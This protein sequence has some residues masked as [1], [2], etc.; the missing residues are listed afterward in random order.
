VLAVMFLAMPGF[1]TWGM[2]TPVLWNTNRAHHEVLLQLPLLPFAAGAFYLVASH[3]VLGA[4]LVGSGLLL[5][6]GAVMATAAFRVLQLSP[7]NWLAW[8]ARGAVLSA[9]VAALVLGACALLPAGAPP[10]LRLLVS[11]GAA[12]AGMAALL[13]LRPQ[14]LGSEATAMLGRF[15]PPLRKWLERRSAP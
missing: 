7:S 3:G 2:S 13:L 10:L 8:F 9:M 6:R 5:A 14:S 12:G 15:F 11:G 4:A 1:V